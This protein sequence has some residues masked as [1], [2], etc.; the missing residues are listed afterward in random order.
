MVSPSC[1]SLV[2]TFI[3][4]SETGMAEIQA[5]PGGSPGAVSRQGMCGERLQILRQTGKS[6]VLLACPADR[7]AGH[8][9]HPARKGLMYA[10]RFMRGA[11]AV[12]RWIS[13]D[14][15]FRRRG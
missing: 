6:G 9:D 15:P 10:Q 12:N 1:A 11:R 5:K 3:Q 13:M 7:S 14:I 4:A 8:G 2:V